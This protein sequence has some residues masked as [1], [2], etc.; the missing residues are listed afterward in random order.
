M[1]PAWREQCWAIAA[2]AVAAVALN[3]LTTGDHLVKTVFTET[4]WA[5]AGVDLSLLASAAIAG[6]AARQLARREQAAPRATAA[7]AGSDAV[8]E[9]AHV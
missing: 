6:W 8:A 5:V 4:Y 2:L 7:P 9:V 1:N 3:A